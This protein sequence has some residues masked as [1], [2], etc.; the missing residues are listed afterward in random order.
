MIDNPIPSIHVKKKSGWSFIF[1]QHSHYN[2]VGPVLYDIHPLQ[3]VSL[4]LVLLLA[5][6]GTGRN[7]RGGGRRREES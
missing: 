4:L 3:M 5:E 1:H 7:G 2:H 6:V